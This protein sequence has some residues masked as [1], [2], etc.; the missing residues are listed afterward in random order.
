M[1]KNCVHHITSR[2]FCFVMRTYVSITWLHILIV[3]STTLARNLFLK[4]NLFNFTLVDLFWLQRILDARSMSC[5]KFSALCK[6]NTCISNLL[7]PWKKT[8]NIRDE[9]FPLIKFVNDFRQVGGFLCV[10]RFPQP[11]KDLHEILFI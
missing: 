7:V 5:L 11:I 4:K 2:S 8:C 10:L 9:R 6:K 3:V 1:K